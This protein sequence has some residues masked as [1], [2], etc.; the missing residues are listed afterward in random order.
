[1]SDIMTIKPDNEFLRELRMES[2]GTMSKCFQCATCSTVC[3]LSPAENPFP[4]KEMIWAQWG[5]KDKLVGDPDIW[6]CHQCNDC[7]VRCPRQ[8]HPG[9]LMAAMRR[10][11]FRYF[12]VPGFMG[13]LL[14]S[15]SGLIPLLL[16]PMI[17]IGAFAWVNTGGDFT[18]F[19]DPHV[20][21]SKFIPDMY[22]EIIFV[23][24]NMLI[25][26]LAAIG[27]F[28]FYKAMVVS[29]GKPRIGFIPALIA[30]VMD[31]LLHKSFSS[32]TETRY[33]KTAHMLILFGFIGALITTTAAVAAIFI[34][35]YHPPFPFLHPI[36]ILGNLSGFSMVIG[37]LVI[38]FQDKN[39]I[40]DM[41]ND[42]YPHKLFLWMLFLVALTG[43]FCQY[44]RIWELPVLAYPTYFIHLV[45]VFFLLWYAPYSQLGHMFYRSLAMVY[46]KSISRQAHTL[47]QTGIVKA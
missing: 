13:K 30:T 46:A 38:F 6:L 29:R 21:F 32:C 43:L 4:R 16:I 47:P 36:K 42:N 33:R 11:V 27:L 39:K 14:A 25:F 19:S 2:D 41:G 22:L 9:A 28:R 20:K 26:G 45:V 35:H 3:E 18:F 44:F 17:I 12:S 10:Y 23:L 1:M 37:I 34:F 7:A 31:I 24:G 8:A 5:M 40:S 15:P